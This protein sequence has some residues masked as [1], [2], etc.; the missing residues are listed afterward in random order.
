M[1][2]ARR[3]DPKWAQLEQRG[4]MLWKRPLSSSNASYARL[5]VIV[6]EVSGPGAHACHNRWQ[7]KQREHTSRR[8]KLF[9]HPSGQLF[10]R[11]HSL[12]CRSFNKELQIQLPQ[13]IV[14]NLFQTNSSSNRSEISFGSSDVTQRSNIV[15]K[16]QTPDEH[17]G[18][19][20]GLLSDKT[21]PSSSIPEM[22]SSS[23]FTLVE[24][25]RRNQEKNSSSS[26]SSNLSSLSIVS[27][28][29]RESETN[30]P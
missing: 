16:Q 12:H 6:I 15:L 24:L 1:D 22:S 19:F 30:E 18:D 29:D 21:L 11:C 7:Q 5:G 20:T 4:N 13:R 10:Q 14:D 23:S 26:L 8:I 2:C 27:D 9:L 25:P 28:N 17:G 3:C